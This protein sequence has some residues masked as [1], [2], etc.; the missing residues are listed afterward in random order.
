MNVD[1]PAVIVQHGTAPDTTPAK[2]RPWRAILNVV[3]WPIRFV[4]DKNGSPSTTKLLICAIVASAWHETP[5][6]AVS[7][8]A[9]LAASFGYSAWKD[10]SSRF[11]A[12]ATAAAS[13]AVSN[14]RSVVDETRR[15][16][17]DETRRTL[18]G[19]TGEPLK[20]LPAQP[21][22]RTPSGDE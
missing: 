1:T 3:L 18:T 22:A 21:D 8:T 12:T 14:A 11:T 9:L 10:Y 2:H 13:L 19:T 15:T 16:L 4:L 7:S 20:S 5:L 6:D 17:T